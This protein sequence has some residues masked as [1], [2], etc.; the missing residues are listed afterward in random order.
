MKKCIVSILNIFKMIDNTLKWNG[1]DITDLFNNNIYSYR[2]DIIRGSKHMTI[3]SDNN[4]II[5]ICIVKEKKTIISSNN[6]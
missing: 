3:Y 6:R 1:S 4:E 5:D 2:T